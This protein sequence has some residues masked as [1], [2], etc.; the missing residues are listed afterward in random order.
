VKLAVYAICKNEEK[1]VQRFWDAVVP[2]LRRG[3]ELVIVDTGSTD[4]T[5]TKFRE[6][7]QSNLIWGSH[8]MVSL[9][10]AFITPWRFDHGRNAALAHVDPNVD[11]CWS[12]DLDEVPQPGWR[13]AIERNWHPELTRLRYKFV[14]SWNEDGTPGV[15]YYSDKLHARAGCSWR[16]PAHEYLRFDYRTEN[17][18]FAHDLVVHH[19]ADYTKERP[20]P[21]P[22]LELGL[23]EEPDNDR[24]QHYLAREY[25]FNNRMVEAADMFE[26]HLSNPKA[27]WRHERSESMMYLAQTGGNDA[28]ERQWLIRAVAECPERKETWMR[29]AEY[30]NDAGNGRFAYELAF[31]AMNLPDDQYYLSNPKYRNDGILNFMNGIKQ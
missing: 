18:V 9:N 20:N 31:K 28:W 30:E 7:I 27:T 19:Y 17:Q 5:V 13:D 16:L 8:D 26:R 15:I 2:E 10:Q 23:R 25:F 4:G 3:D 24:N 6:L 22:L 21:L 14:W 1:H 29:W 12:L 11:A